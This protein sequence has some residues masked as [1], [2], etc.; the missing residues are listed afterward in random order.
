MMSTFM[1]PPK[2]LTRIAFTFLSAIRILNAS[3]TCSSVAPPPTSRKLAGFAA[4]K[5]D[6]VHGSH[7]EAGAID[8]ARYVAVEPD[9]I[10]PMF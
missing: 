8:E 5:L 9:V 2:M 7:G 4:V 6:D 10:E 1:I 3:V